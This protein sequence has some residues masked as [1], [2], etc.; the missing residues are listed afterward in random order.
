MAADLYAISLQGLAY[1]RARIEAS[2]AN[3]ANMNMVASAP[4][5]VYRLKQVNFAAEVTGVPS[6]TEVQSVKA[7]Y[8]PDHP[9]ADSQGFI[10]QPD[11]N[12]ASEM[13]QLNIA[14]RA[15]EANIRAFNALK[16]MNAKAMEIGK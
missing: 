12:L 16:D 1:E 2:S 15:Y 6:V 10:Y 14:N 8:Q 4:S 11:V 9:M 3:I 7:S 5:E 13:L